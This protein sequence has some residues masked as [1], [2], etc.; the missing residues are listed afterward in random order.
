MRGCAA[1]RQRARTATLPR[2]RWAVHVLA[3]DVP[4]VDLIHRWLELLALTGIGGRRSRGAGTFRVE[5]HEPALLPLTPEPR[6]LL[7]SWLSPR[8]EEV[9]AGLFHPNTRFG[10]RTDERVGWISSPFWLSERSRRVLMVAEGSY[11]AP[12]LPAPVGRLVDVTPGE[13][14]DRHRV[15]RYG[16]GLFL[17]EERLP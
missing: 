8:P 12:T 4:T 11:V 10:Y 16:F 6:G 1:A 17:D 14:G 2:L 15:F 9:S 13:P 3:R 5:R 7:L